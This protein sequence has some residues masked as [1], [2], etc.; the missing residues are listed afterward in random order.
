MNLVCDPG[1]P[2]FGLYSDDLNE[3]L[4]SRAM[5]SQL[6]APRADP[7]T[8]RSRLVSTPPCADKLPPDTGTLL[9]VL[10]ASTF[11]LRSGGCRV[12]RPLWAQE[13]MHR[14]YSFARL[15][16]TRN[17]LGKSPD[18]DAIAC[19]LGGCFRDL[20]VGGERNVLPCSDILRNVVTD[21]GAL[22]GGPD[23]ITLETKIEDIS[24]PAYKRRALVLGAAELVSNALLHAF[25]T[26]LAGEIGVDLT[27]TSPTSA[28]LRVVD[29]GNGFTDSC[30]NLEY[31]V[32]SAL[33]ALLE[34]DLAYYRMAGWTI[35]EIEF[36]VTG[37]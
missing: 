9:R 23:N 14:A 6:V 12:L 3:P 22:F 2:A 24:L 33:A 19:D 27:A 11:P 34:A 16:D 28:C 4:S 18:E 20:T 32:G 35:A 26:R 36:P 30:P 17:R 29:N 5:V 10:L 25:P 13:A 8:E 7:S 15:V 1:D 21:L 37:S 31:G